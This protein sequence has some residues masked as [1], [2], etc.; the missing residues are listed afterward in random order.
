LKTITQRI[1]QAIRRILSDIT[2]KSPRF[3]RLAARRGLSGGGEGKRR[4]L[5]TNRLIHDYRMIK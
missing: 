3:K 2:A 4:I 1:A 5:F